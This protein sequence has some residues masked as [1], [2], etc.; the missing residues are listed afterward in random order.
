MTDK[1]EIQDK[2][3]KA[4]EE[5]GRK[6]GFKE[7]MAHLLMKMSEDALGA[8]LGQA[9]T[10]SAIGSNSV[11][12]ADF[13]DGIVRDMAFNLYVVSSDT[14]LN[15]GASKFRAM[16]DAMSYLDSEFIARN[17][18]HQTSAVPL[19]ELVRKESYDSL[20][21]RYFSEKMYTIPL[22]GPTGIMKKNGINQR[23]GSRPH[24]KDIM[25]WRWSEGLAFLN[26][27]ERVECLLNK[28]M[29][30]DGLELVERLKDYARKKIIQERLKNEQAELIDAG[31]APVITTTIDRLNLEEDIIAAW[32]NSKADDD[33]D[34][35]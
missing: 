1:E 4:T 5:I 10:N 34:I 13:L 32:Y 19:E 6:D 33:I 9:E 31:I 25:E 26:Y 2:V 35:H 7:N 3:N 27:R 17:Y 11:I 23:W 8:Q 22:S 30:G 24:E 20:R 21:H 14:A 18:I 15:K 28:A 16:A 12:T 29:V